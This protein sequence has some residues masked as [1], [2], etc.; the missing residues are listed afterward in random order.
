MLQSWNR[1]IN[2]SDGTAESFLAA[3]LFGEEGG[4]GE[5]KMLQRFLGECKTVRTGNHLAV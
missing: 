5:H 3:S 4:E 1:V 2:R